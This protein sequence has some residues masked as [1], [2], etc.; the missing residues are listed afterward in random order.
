MAGNFG[1]RNQG[2]VNDFSQAT[3]VVRGGVDDFLFLLFRVSNET[4]IATAVHCIDRLFEILFI[5]RILGN[6][7]KRTRFVITD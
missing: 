4:H 7:K 5:F 1:F 3:M 2:Q 6:I